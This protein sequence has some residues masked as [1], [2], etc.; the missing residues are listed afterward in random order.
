VVPADA[1]TRPL[2]A[3]QELVRFACERGGHDNITVA[4]LPCLPSPLSAP[5]TPTELSLPVMGA[6]EKREI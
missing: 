3:A 1:R 2:E 5:Y 4:V 6:G